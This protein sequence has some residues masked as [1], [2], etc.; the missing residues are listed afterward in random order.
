MTPTPRTDSIMITWNQASEDVVVNYEISYVYNG[1]C[2]NVPASS[3]MMLNSTTMSYIVSDLEEFSPYTITV[4]A[5]NPA[6]T[7]DAT[8]TA[9]TMIASMHLH[10]T[11][12]TN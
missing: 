3:P 12:A 1:T 8:V 10:I 2:P 7:T 6:G 9:T 5:I 11:D 4:T